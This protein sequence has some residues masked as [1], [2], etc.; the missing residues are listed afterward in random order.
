MADSHRGAPDNEDARAVA[1]DYDDY[2]AFLRTAADFGCV[3][4]QE[5]E[6]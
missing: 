6:A 4:W 1:T 2:K 5:I 3:Q